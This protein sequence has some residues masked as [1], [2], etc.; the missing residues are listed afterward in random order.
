MKPLRVLIGCEFSGVV[1]DEFRK[2]GHDAWSCDLLPCESDPAFHIK[3]DLLTVLGDSPGQWDLGIF[4]PECKYLN[5]AGVRW[6]YKDGR[7]WIKDKDGNV[8]GENPIDPE[9]W[10]NMLKG[11][12]FF[13]KCYNAKIP[14][15][16]VENSEMH[17]HAAK[18]I[19][20]KETQIIQPWQFGHGEVKASHYWLRNLP[21]LKPSAIVEGREP[22]VHYASPGPDRWKERS[23][24]LQGIAAA[25]AAQWGSL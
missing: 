14:R 21:L 13:L 17:P 20:V 9:R 16:A 25:M 15:I 19:G 11:A 2:L 5:H 18:I 23:R 7:R 1:R 24:T 6:L 8:T 22:R 3:S 4:H 10:Q 12:D